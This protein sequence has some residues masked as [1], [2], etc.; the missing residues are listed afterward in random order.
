[1]RN[2]IIALTVLIAATA[3]AANPKVAIETT[4]GTIVVELNEEKAPITV[5]NFLDYAKAGHYDGL[6]FHRVI[7][8]F[9]IQGGGM[10]E[11]IVPRKT[12][13][14][15]TNEADNGLANNRGT[16]AMARTSVV[17]SATS[18]FFINLVNNGFLNHTSKTPRGWGYAVFGKVVEGMDVV[19]AIGAV[20]TG[21]TKGMK[22][23]PVEPVTIKTVKILN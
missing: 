22:D 8:G 17:N 10:D 5:K 23:V 6:V 21:V 16:I 1:M 15:I 20:K 11:N 12:N 14:P 18:Q 2:M 3:F 7:N 13:A 19:D 9:M 4:K